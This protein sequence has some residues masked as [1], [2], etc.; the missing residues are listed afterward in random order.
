MYCN[1]CGTQ[2]P[3]NS[4]FCH[5]CGHN[6]Q[7]DS[8][9]TNEQN[10]SSQENQNTE[11]N[12]S[13]QNQSFEQQN[14]ADWSNF[15]VN[16]KQVKNND[17]LDLILKIFCTVFAIVFA[18]QGL[19][20]IFSNLFNL[21]SYFYALRFNPI[22]IFMIPISFISGII[23]ILTAFVLV[24]LGFKHSKEN[25]TGLFLALT[26]LCV[27]VIIM[28]IIML[29]IRMLFNL[30]TFGM[31]SHGVFHNTFLYFSLPII[32]LCGAFCLLN[33]LKQTPDFNSYTQN[34]GEKLSNAAKDVKNAFCE[35][36]SSISS[37]SQNNTNNQ[38]NNSQYQNN[39]QYNYQQS[40]N[41]F[42]QYNNVASTPLKQDRNIIVFIILNLIT[43]GIY[44]F[45]TVYSLA[46][47]V[48]KACEGD[49]KTTSG[50]LIF[51]LLSLVTC[52]IYS[53]YWHYALANRIAANAPRYG[54]N[55]QEDGTSVLLWMLLGSLLC[56]I[57]YWIAYHIIFKNM[58]ILAASYNN[59]R[60]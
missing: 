19:G 46:S 51:I 9:T 29:I 57:G 32:C 16:D 33:A 37:H 5:N 23:Y 50:L 17:S 35:L 4:R 55:F 36:I 26:V 27:L 31:I 20:A 47:D 54:M 60:F 15:Q 28:L 12:N 6:L 1:N 45:Y 52:G 53:F 42:S 24:L 22:F 30:I 59:R 14:H 48:N 38:Y 3:D 7:A 34:I 43:C 40:N 2:V 13:Q 39:T 8:E 11:N 10:Q 44:G 25:S 21:D 58:N 41:N 18:Y 56:G 49:G